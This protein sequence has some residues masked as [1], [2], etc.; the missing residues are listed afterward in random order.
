MTQEIQSSSRASSG[1]NEFILH[2][3]TKRDIKVDVKFV[4]F[5]EPDDESD[6]SCVLPAN[7]EKSITSQSPNIRC[8]FKEE[9]GIHISVLI[10][11]TGHACIHTY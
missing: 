1:K 8:D 4:K 5:G 3:G 2:N 10:S 6:Q 11:E 7:S 9:N